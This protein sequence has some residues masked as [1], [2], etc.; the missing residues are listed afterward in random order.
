MLYLLQQYQ[1][2]ILTLLQM[3]T[4]KFS[5]PSFKSRVGRVGIDIF[6]LSGKPVLLGG[7]E[8]LSSL[9]IQVRRIPSSAST[10]VGFI[11]RKALRIFLCISL[12]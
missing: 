9:I 2:I 5:S 12:R 6:Y 11:R 3:K 8:G 7:A 4:K 1:E 10:L